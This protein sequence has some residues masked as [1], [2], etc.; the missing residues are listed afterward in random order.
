MVMLLI[1][2]A[3]VVGVG[4]LVVL[5]RWLDALDWRR[6]LVAFRLSLPRGV[7]AGDVAHWLTLVNGSTHATRFPLL[8]TPPVAIEIAAT[9][10]GISHYVLVPKVLRSGLLAG[11]R[12]ALPGV[13]FE[14]TPEY[15]AN[16]PWIWWAAEA[17][18]TNHRRP[19]RTELAIR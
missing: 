9:S 15:L 11:L 8:P 18:L 4:G 13:R 17:A 3:G 12:A 16:R 2:L 1:V 19:L 5:V 7:K 14:E 10:R 6:S